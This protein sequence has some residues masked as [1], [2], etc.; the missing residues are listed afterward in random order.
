MGNFNVQKPTDE[1]LQ[2]LVALTTALS[3]KYSI[4]PLGKVIYFRKSEWPPYMIA[5]DGYAIA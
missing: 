3:K 2:S 5:V 4:N 1:Q